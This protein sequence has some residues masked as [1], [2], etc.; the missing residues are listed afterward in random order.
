MAEL[1]P[2]PFCGGKARLL[3]KQTPTND[4]PL[5]REW[6]YEYIVRCNKCRASVGYYR[7]IET[8]KNAWNRRAE[9]GNE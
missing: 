9:D 6:I 2:C 7:K 1:K 5:L 4:N 8:A 3:T